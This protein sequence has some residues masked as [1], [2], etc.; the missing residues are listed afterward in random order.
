VKGPKKFKVLTQTYKVKH[1]KTLNDKKYGLLNG[2]T[3][4]DRGQVDLASHKLT[5]TK[6]K[7]TYLH[8]FLHAVLSTGGIIHEHENTSE[9]DLVS[10]LAPLL[11][12]TMRENPSVVAY[13]MKG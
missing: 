5:S 2:R 3:R 11:L 12:H 1:C 6:R 10:G 8:E 4:P 9:E 13:L 7:E